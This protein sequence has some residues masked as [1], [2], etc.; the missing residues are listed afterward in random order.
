MVCAGVRLFG[1]WNN[2]C[3]F[4]FLSFSACFLL[5]CPEIPAA[6]PTTTASSTEEPAGTLS[7]LLQHLGGKG[8][9]SN[10]PP[11]MKLH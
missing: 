5:S 1:I 10:R 4:Y 11:E 2:T 8:L 9:L 3:F 7:L 6:P